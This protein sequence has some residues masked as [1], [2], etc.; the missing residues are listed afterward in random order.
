[1]TPILDFF[2]WLSGHSPLC[3]TPNFLVAHTSTFTQVREASGLLHPGMF[4]RTQCHGLLLFSAPRTLPQLLS[5]GFSYAGSSHRRCQGP[6]PCILN[7][8]FHFNHTKRVPASLL[9]PLALSEG[10][11][12]PENRSLAIPNVTSVDSKAGSDWAFGT[13]FSFFFWQYRSLNSGTRTC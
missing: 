5:L 7:L 2:P 11:L 6:C 4:L 13:A 1:M 12:S 3:F 10:I 8:S 9:Q